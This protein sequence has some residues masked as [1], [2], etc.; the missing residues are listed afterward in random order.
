MNNVQSANIIKN[1]CK[2]KKVAVNTLLSECGIRKGLIYDM[3]KRDKTPSPEIFEQIADYLGCSVDYLLGR[4]EGG[5]AK[6][7]PIPATG[8]GQNTKA[9]YFMELVDHLTAD[10]QQ[11]L[12]LQLRAWTAQNERQGLAGP[13]AAGGTDQEAL[14]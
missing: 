3:E 6:K 5:N 1:L 7:K 14:L 9:N 2:D 11:L 4:E 13:P 8:N 10:Q 12:L